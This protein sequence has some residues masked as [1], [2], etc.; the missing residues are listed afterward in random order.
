MRS[1]KS[2]VTSVVFNLISLI[3]NSS[4]SEECLG[5]TIGER[6]LYKYLTLAFSLES[7]ITCDSL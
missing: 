2:D 1:G 7:L 5:Q 6:L 4:Y 3:I